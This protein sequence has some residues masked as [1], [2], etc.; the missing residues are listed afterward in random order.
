MPQAFLDIEI[1]DP[2]SRQAEIDSH[3]RAIQFLK[4]RG[5]ELGL[6][7]TGIT[8]LSEE[9]KDLL[10][11]LYQSD[12]SSRDQGPITLTPP[13]PPRGG[14]LIFALSST[15]PKT[16]ANFLS[17]CTNSKPPSKT[18]KK[19]LHYKHTPFHRIITSFIA[20]SGDVTRHDG[21]G[22]ESIY[23]PKFN[24]E[25]AG[26]SAKFDGR[27]VLAMANS[28]KNSNSSQFFVTLTDDPVKLKKL[29]GKYVVFGRV[30]EGWEVLDAM[31]AVGSEDDGGRPKE[32]VVIKDCGELPE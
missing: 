28:G 1:G 11:E 4:K 25:K 19:P 6:T 17:L 23:G 31:S 22:G 10:L 20:Q 30:V 5:P 8:D 24:D 15:T 7:G 13:F 26:L 27:G 14:R 18:T 21:S 12:P 29:D 32:M 16:T 2:A 9:Q 3:E